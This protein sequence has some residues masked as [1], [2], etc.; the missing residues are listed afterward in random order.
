M[1]ATKANPFRIA[2]VLTPTP[3]P[4]VSRTSTT[5]AGAR[6]QRAG[7]DRSPAA[8]SQG[9]TP[10]RVHVAR[11]PRPFAVLQRGRHDSHRRRPPL[12]LQPRGIAA[13][14]AARTSAGTRP[15]GS[16]A[17]RSSRP[18]DAPVPR[19]R[20]RPPLGAQSHSD[21][22]A[23]IKPWAPFMAVLAALRATPTRPRTA[24]GKIR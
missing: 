5:E 17:M 7:G 13:L 14:S 2:H 10:R 24:M 16:R 9:A 8:G 1:V 22:L 11:R 18:P 15:T 3:G 21:Q 6:S 23:V 19:R 20:R 4:R 12:L